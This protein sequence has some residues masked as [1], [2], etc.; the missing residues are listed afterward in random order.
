MPADL[1]GVGGIVPAVLAGP[2]AGG[3]GGGM[4]L[5]TVIKRVQN[6]RDATDD[7][8]RAHGLEDALYREFIAHV[9]SHAGKR[10]MREMAQEILQTDFIKFARWRA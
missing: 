5:A 9:A 6:I 2:E 7:D 10:E 3:L 4:N 8:E 1:C